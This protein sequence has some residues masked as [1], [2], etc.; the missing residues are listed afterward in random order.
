VRTRAGDAHHL[1][2]KPVSIERRKHARGT[3]IPSSRARLKY[4][5]L[6]AH[7]RKIFK[8][9]LTSGARHTLGDANL[10]DERPSLVRQG[11]HMKAMQ[12]VAQDPALS[13]PMLVFGLSSH[14]F[15]LFEP[16]PRLAQVDKAP[17]R[18]LHTSA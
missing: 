9:P 16:S 10:G 3:N 7:R 4:V 6:Q 8:E 11:A 5:L 1:L 14:P 18:L 17:D 12:P 13:A 2:P 15:A